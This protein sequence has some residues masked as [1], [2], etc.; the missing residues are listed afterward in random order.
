[1][2]RT[3]RIMMYLLVAGISLNFVAC[4]QTKSNE[5]EQSGHEHSAANEEETESALSTISKNQAQKILSSYLKIKDNL[6]NTDGEAASASAKELLTLLEGNEDEIFNELKIDTEHIMGTK[7]AGHQ[8]DHF[9]S[10]S[11]N[12]YAL[13]KLTTANDVTLYRQYCPMAFN[14]EGAYWL[15]AEKEVN[16]PYFGDKMLHCGSVKETIA[17]AVE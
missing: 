17:I 3:N 5:S 11:D 2:K 15:S 8:R 9:N 6:V 1:M 7:D 12:V 14:N 4:G 13:V 10:L 16:N